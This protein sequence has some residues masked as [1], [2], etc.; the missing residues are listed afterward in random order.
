VK[1][2]VGP[3]NG[4]NQTTPSIAGAGGAIVMN[5]ALEWLTV[6]VYEVHEK[7]AGSCDD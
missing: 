4:S 3:A 6:I 2:A 5:H 1:T 7:S